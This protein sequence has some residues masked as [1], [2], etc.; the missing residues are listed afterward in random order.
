MI[1]IYKNIEDI[2]SGRLVGRGGRRLWRRQPRGRRRWGR[3]RTFLPASVLAARVF[4]IRFFDVGEERRK[5]FHH[6]TLDRK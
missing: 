5:R 6:Y 3:R 2:I 1:I 4:V